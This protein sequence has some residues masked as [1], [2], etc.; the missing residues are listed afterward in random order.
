MSEDSPSEPTLAQDLARV[1]NRH[2]AENRSG[3]PDFIL[4]HYLMG[5]LRAWDLGTRARDRWYGDVKEP[6]Q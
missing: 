4:A 5:C 1:L 2:S 3:T 6:G